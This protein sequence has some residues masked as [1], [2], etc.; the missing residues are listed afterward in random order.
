MI[1]ETEAYSGAVDKAS[2]AYKNKMTKRTRVMFKEGGIAYVYLCYGIHHLF[3][4]VTNLEGHP[5][6]VLIR[7]IQ[8]LDWILNPGTILRKRSAVSVTLSNGP[9]KLTKAMKID[10]RHNGLDLTGD[11]IWI[12]NG[13]SPLT[14]ESIVS[15][16]RIGVDYAGEDANLD[17]RFYIKD[18][19]WISRI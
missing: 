18:N 17:W 12:E 13:E 1:V 7:A 19:P 15:S 9:G 11:E 14:K 16:K 2:H 5:D 4:V 3:N 8:P 6:A 10:L